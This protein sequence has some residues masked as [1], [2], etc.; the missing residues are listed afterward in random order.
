MNVVF[1]LSLSIQI[2]WQIQIPM[3][4]YLP[5]ITTLNLFTQAYLLQLKIEEASWRLRSGDLGIPPNPEDRFT[6]L[7][8]FSH[9]LKHM[10]S[11]CYAFGT[12]GSDSVLPKVSKS[13]ANLRRNG[14]KAEHSRCQVLKGTSKQKR[15]M[16][17]SI[18]IGRGQSW[19]SRDTMLLWK[20]W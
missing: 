11:V 15:N 2:I 8:N 12:S 13:W 10:S 19:R 18:P 20:C 7:E 5:L 3:A 16:N 14:E 4:F 17:K 1:K 6:L 9:T